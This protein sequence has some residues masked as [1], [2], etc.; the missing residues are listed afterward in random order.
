MIGLFAL[1]M[2]G[3]LAAMAFGALVLLVT[4]GKVLFWLV[5]LPFRLAFRLVFLP[6][7]LLRF[8]LRLVFGL[9]LLPLAAIAV[10]IGVGL[11]AFLGLFLVLVPL[12]PILLIGLVIWGIVK[13]T[14]RTAVPAMR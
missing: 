8:A 13:M 14:T 11:A 12:L 3:M 10:T 6:F 1:A 5:F 2:M 7:Y 4:V 9:L